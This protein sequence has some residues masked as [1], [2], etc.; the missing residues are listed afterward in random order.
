MTQFTGS[1]ASL[2]TAIKDLDAYVAAATTPG[3]LHEVESDLWALAL[4]VARAALAR[5][6]EQGGTGDVGAVHVDRQGRERRLLA[7]RPLTYRSLFGPVVLQRAYYYDAGHGGCYPL[8]A[9]LALPERSYSYHLQRLVGLL[10]VQ[11]AYAEGEATLFTFLGVRIPK[12]MGEHL[13]ADMA[14]AVVAFREQAPPPQ[15]EGLVTIVQADAKGVNVVRPV[16]KAPPGPK[17]SYK[18]SERQ[19]KKKMANAWTIYTA[20][21]SAGTPPVPLNRTISATMQPK[22]E[23]FA[24]MLA[25]LARRGPARGV[26]L[27]LADGDPVL[28]AMQQEQLPDALSCL[29]WMHLQERV[30]EAAYVFH[31]KGSAAAK[32]W[33]D[34]TNE[35]LMK[36]DVVTVI[37]GLRQSL[38]KGQKTLSVARKSSLNAVIGYMVANKHRMPYGTFMLA[39]YPIGTGSI[40]GGVRHLIGDRMDRTGMRWTEPGAQ[41]MLDLRSVHVNGQMADFHAYRILREQERMYGSTIAFQ[42]DLCQ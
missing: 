28:D 42:T 29:D 10:D 34:K 11:N 17:L 15:N 2:E 23:A 40:E 19:G 30:W 5:M 7:I 13:V 33:V 38:T 24:L 1:I 16:E 12:S 37:R 39:G 32:A 14:E 3:P 25:D 20:N 26:V 41:A 36:D 6:V 18:P 22:R 35:R 8:D 21:P 9:E 27:F 31:P 4:R